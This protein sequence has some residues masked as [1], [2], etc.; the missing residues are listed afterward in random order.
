MTALHDE[1]NVM[2]NQAK[3][4][5]FWYDNMQNSKF[6]QTLKYRRFICKIYIQVCLKSLFGM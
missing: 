6:I 4:V 3:D 5:L 1:V 2:L